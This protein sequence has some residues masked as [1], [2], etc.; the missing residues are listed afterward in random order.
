MDRFLSCDWGTSSFRLRL[1]KDR[2]IEGEI[3]SEKGIATSFEEWKTQQSLKRLSFFQAYLLQ[4]IQ[5]LEERQGASLKQVPLVLSGMA[6]SSIG[7]IELPYKTLPFKTDGSDLEVRKIE[8][9]ASFPHPLII[10]SGASTT[11]DVLR[12]EETLLVGCADSDASG[13]FLFPGT[14]SKHITVA[15]GIATDFKTYMT[16]EFFHL[17]AT[18]SILSNSVVENAFVKEKHKNIFT[19][20][21]V[22][23]AVLNLLNA[24]FYVR[25][26]QLFQK[27]SKEEN[28]HYLSGLLIGAE[29]KEL[30][31]Y[32]PATI[33]LVCGEAMSELYSVAFEILGFSENICYKRD[34]DALIEGQLRIWKQ[35]A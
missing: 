11:R 29:I 2:K 13:V 12:G 14:H 34:A 32:S 15:N 26:N 17:L 10:I 35:H 20:A 33:T 4:M 18:K 1:I 7:M 21:V 25:T 3:K 8:G 16:G 24:S 31:Q 19:E 30:K 23:G 27:N 6:S 28:Y 9:S 5:A 22:E